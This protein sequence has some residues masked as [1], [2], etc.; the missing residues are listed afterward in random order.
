MSEI[1][2]AGALLAA[3]LLAASVPSA[4]A[5]ITVDGFRD[6]E[7]ETQYAELAVQATT[8]NW[9]ANNTLANLHAGQDGSKLA[10]FVGGRADGNAILLFIDSKSGGPG[11]IA[12]N[13]ITSGN[14]P[15]TINNLGPAES[16][17]GM[18]FEDG[19]NPDYAIRI[20][21]SGNEAYVNRYDL[22]AGTG[23]YVGQT[24]A[25][26]VPASGFISEIR[27]LWSDVTGTAADH[28]NGVEMK[29]NLASLGVPSGAGQTV[30][31]MAV[32]VNDNSDYG[33]NQV[34]ASRTSTTNDIGGDINNISFETEAGTQTLSLTVDN[35]DTDGDSDP[36]ITDPD[37]DN[38]GLDDTVETGTGIYVSAF[39]TGTDPLIED[40]DG[41]T[42][43][44]G[45]E[46]S[47]SA[48][49]YISDPNKANYT[50]MAVPGDFTTPQ[51][52]EDGSA[53]NAMTQAGTSLTSQY[54][55][56]LDYKFT[57]LGPI[58]YKFAAEGAWT[59]NWGDNGNN[60]NATIAAS[61][62]HTFS[63]N[64]DTL[65]YS[66]TRTTFAD[67]AAFLTAYGLSAGSDDDG[68]GVPNENEFT[69]N[70]DPTA[71]DSDG[72][73]LSDGADLDPLVAAGGYS[74]WAATN[75]GGQSA[76]LDYDYDGVANGV[77]YFMGESGSGF[78]ANPVPVGTLITWP[79]DPAATGVSF[80]VWSSDNLSAWTD[81]TGSADTSD[82]ASV[83][84]TIPSGDPAR[85]VRLEV[86][87]P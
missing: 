83:K 70:T 72:D 12:N 35:L 55:W 57:A 59:H 38:D 44:D 80:K 15:H 51:W 1:R 31:L 10:V 65:A 63:F 43:L 21:G 23:T 16:D 56:T 9:G 86:L 40:T 48:L 58:Q 22:Q 68:D 84:Y 26:I 14:E 33:S 24:V 61:G 47:G 53:G 54:E 79:R 17:T 41:D 20:W 50:S 75:A 76:D 5:D 11:T 74:A 42:H 37:D 87:V 18:T 77:E 7:I 36:D 28:V 85:F 27:T 62:F 60:I 39:D 13:Q 34:L 82:P 49:G 67:S 6:S 25:N 81:V 32:L 71:T 3:P 2:R 45:D 46:V 73:G 52:K 69:A 29:L 8:S 66:L 4:L 30:K 64:N 19:F 78:T